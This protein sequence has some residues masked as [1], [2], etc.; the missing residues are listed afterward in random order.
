MFN[1]MRGNLA[2][3]PVEE[4]TLAAAF[5]LIESYGYIL[6]QAQILRRETGA[7]WPRLARS[8]RKT[9]RA[10]WLHME[11]CAMRKYKTMFCVLMLMLG[12]RGCMSLPPASPLAVECPKP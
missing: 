6:V 12:A 5:G 2:D 1:T 10:N 7:A 11:G 8:T 3:K 4:T 9:P